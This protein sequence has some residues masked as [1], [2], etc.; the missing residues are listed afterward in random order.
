MLAKA[1]S[2]VQDVLGEHQDGVVA[3]QTWLS[4]AESEPADHDLAVTAGRLCERERTAVRDKRAAFPKAWRR[5]TKRRRTRW[6]P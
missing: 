2:K 4:I 3:A 1:L 5:A 6:L